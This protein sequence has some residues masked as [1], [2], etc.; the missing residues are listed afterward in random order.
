MDDGGM[1]SHKGFHG[2]FTIQLALAV[3]FPDW[4]ASQSP[5]NPS[6]PGNQACHPIPGNQPATKRSVSLALLKDLLKEY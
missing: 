1:H 3:W 4:L 2:F 6:Q 5:A